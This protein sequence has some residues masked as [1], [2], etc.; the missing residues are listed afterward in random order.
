MQILLDN[1]EYRLGVLDTYGVTLSE[2]HC[3]NVKEDTKLPESEVPGKLLVTSQSADLAKLAI[4]FE[5][6]TQR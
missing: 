1:N 5:M 6:P 4:N 2:Y 3:T